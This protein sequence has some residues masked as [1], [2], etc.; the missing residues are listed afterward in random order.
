MNHAADYSHFYCNAQWWF[1]EPSLFQKF[2][3]KKELVIYQNRFIDI[4][5]S[6][7]EKIEMSDIT[8]IFYHYIEIITRKEIE[9]A[10]G[11]LTCWTP[12]SLR[13]LYW[14]KYKSIMFLETVS[15]YDLNLYLM[16]VSTKCPHAEKISLPTCWRLIALVDL[17]QIYT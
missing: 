10:W 7:L 5:Y 4:K 3:E 16:I 2:K 6:C 12:R 17:W 1:P 13:F 8:N 14:K 15:A 11:D 9:I